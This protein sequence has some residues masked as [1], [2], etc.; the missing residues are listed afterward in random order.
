MTSKIFKAKDLLLLF[1]ILYIH[2][3]QSIAASNLLIC[4]G[5][6]LVHVVP[7]TYSRDWAPSWSRVPRRWRSSRPRPF[8]KCP[9]TI[10]R[11]VPASNSSFILFCSLSEYLST[12]RPPYS[13][14]Y[15]MD[16]SL[17]EIIAEDTVSFQL[18]GTPMVTSNN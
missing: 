15:T 12:T 8:S 18:I 14:T 6:C 2:S 16:R 10:N 1:S 13:H 5:L 11:L 17:D 7:L 9:Q 3:V 4:T